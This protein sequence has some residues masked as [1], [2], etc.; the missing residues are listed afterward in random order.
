LR[1]S[2][3]VAPSPC[4]CTAFKVA[5]L[6]DTPGIVVGGMELSQDEIFIVGV[7]W[8]THLTAPSPLE[9]RCTQ[10][11]HKRRSSRTQTFVA[12]RVEAGC[13]LAIV[14]RRLVTFRFEVGSAKPF[15]EA[16]IH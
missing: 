11:F 1:T 5:S 10:G 16:V 7:G 14:N 8:P 2:L 6:S 12:M 13:K 15:R 4:A 3:A 9:D